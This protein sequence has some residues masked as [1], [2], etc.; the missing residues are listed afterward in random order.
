MYWYILI[1]SEIRWTAE[2]LKK[3]IDKVIDMLHNPEFSS[4]QVD[5]DLYKR[6]WKT[7]L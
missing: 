7:L 6:S 1:H 4:K 2:E 3:V 5:P